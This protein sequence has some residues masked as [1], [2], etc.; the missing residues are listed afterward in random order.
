M[1]FH[2]FCIKG[3]A[4]SLAKASE[5]MGLAGKSDD[6][7]GAEAPQMWREGRYEE[8]L[9]Y[10]AEDAKATLDLAQAGNREREVRW[11]SRKGKLLRC[12]L[13]QGWK[14]VSEALQEPEPDTSWMENPWPRSRFTG[15]LDR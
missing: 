8:V 2:F 1:M 5:G 11:V 10:V 14:T 7:E 15:W 12:E 6:V 13:K 9:A 3:F 4:I